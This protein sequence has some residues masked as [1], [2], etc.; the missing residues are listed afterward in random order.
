M[1]VFA[2]SLSRSLTIAAA[3]LFFT[4]A[5]GAQQQAAT[6]SPGDLQQQ[7]QELKQQYQQTTQLLEQ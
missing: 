7:L 2:R 3:T 4:G 5:A 6:P 1:D